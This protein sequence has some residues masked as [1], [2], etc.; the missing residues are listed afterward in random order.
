M[1]RTST[2]KSQEGNNN[3]IKNDQIRRMNSTAMD[4]LEDIRASKKAREKN[5]KIINNILSS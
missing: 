1:N 4:N 3:L 5:C 2:L